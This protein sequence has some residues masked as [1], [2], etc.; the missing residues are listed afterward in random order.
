[1]LLPFD[2]QP[3]DFSLGLDP[4]FS[5]IADTLYQIRQIRKF[6]TTAVVIVLVFCRP[7]ENVVERTLSTK[8]TPHIRD[9]NIDVPIRKWVENECRNL[10]LPTR[11]RG[12]FSGR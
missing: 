2:T 3:K 7:V 5:Q 11:K 6:V 9:A 12:G 1:M 10:T 8:H 4:T